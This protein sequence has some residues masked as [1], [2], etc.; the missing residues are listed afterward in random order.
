MANIRSIRS[1]IKSLESTGQITSSMKMVAAAKLRR[2]QSDLSHFRPF[3]DMSSRLLSEALCATD[4]TVSPLLFPHKDSQKV[5]FV[6]VVGN[7]GLCGSYNQ[8]LMRL[9]SELSAAETRE[10]SLILC[11]AW[12]AGLKTSPA[13]PLLRRFDVSDTPT[14]DEARELTDYLKDLYLSGQTDEIHIIYTEYLSVLRQTPTQKHLLPL[15]KPADAKVREYIFEPDE[16]S[17]LLTLTEQHLFSQVYLTLLEARTSEHSA[18]MTAMTSASDNAT[19]LTTEL[20][21]KLNHARQA[22]IT[23]EISEIECGSAALKNTK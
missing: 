17:L 7:R 22:S 9:F 23:S 13:L 10:C 14:P 15:V 3:A 12:D 21:L 11:G 18:R 4:R 16:K 8:N 19:A 1:R 6:L 5:C 20:Q 2:V